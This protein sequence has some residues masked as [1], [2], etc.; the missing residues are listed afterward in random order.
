MRRFV[1][2]ALALVVSAL[3]SPSGAMAQ[4]TITL[5]GVVKSQDGQPVSGAQVIVVNTGTMERRTAGTRPT[6]EFRVLGLYSGKYSVEVRALGYKPVQDSVQLIIGQRARLTIT[7]ERGAAEIAGVAVTAERVRQVEVQRVSIS[8]PVLKEE[9]ENLPMNSRGVM[10]LAAIAPGVK[11]YAPQSG[12]ALPSAGGAPDLRF[13]NLYMDGVEMKSL[14]N[15]NLVGIPQTGSPLPQ[16]ALEEFRVYLNPYDAEYSRAASYVISAVSRRGTD[17]WEGSAFGFFQGKDYIARTFIQERNNAQ[18]P[19]YGRQQYGLNLRG[20]IARG[21]LFFAGSYEGTLTDNYIDVVPATNFANW[22]QYRGAFLAPQKNHT[23]FGRLTAT[24]NETSTYDFMWSTRKLE[25]EGNFGGRSS[26]LAG[27]SQEYL[28]HTAQLRHRWLPTTNLVNELS[29][30]YVQWDHTE[31]PLFPGPTKTYPG[32]ITGTAGFPL[33][34]NEKHYRIVNRSTY[35]LDDVRGSHLIK[36][37]GELSRISASQFLPNNRDGAFTFTTDTSTNPNNAS[38]A[39]GF[40][41]PTGTDDARASA[42]GHTIGFYVNDEWR[43]IPNLA[44]NLGLRYDAE[45]NTLNNDYTVPWAS[46]PVLS[47]IAALQPYLNRGDRK[48]DMNNVS[49]RVSFLL[50][51]FKT[52]RTFLRGGFAIMF[53]R[54]TSFIGFQERLNSEW[55]TYNFVNP[56]TTDPAVLRARV[57]QGGVNAAAQPIL[58]KN[59]LKTPENRQVSIGIGHQFNESFG[60]NVDYVRQDIKNLYVRLNPNWFS[61]SLNRRVLTPAYGDIILWD[62]FGTAKFNGMVT[63]GT[64]NRSGQR[65]N[66]AYTLGFYESDFDGNLAPVFPNRS[67]YDMQPTTGDERHRFV[68]S[69]INRLPLG[70]QFSSV[71]SFASP[72]PYGVFDGRQVNDNNVTFDDFPN[73][74]RTLR[75]SNDWENWYKTVDIR[76]QRALIT[77][78]T[79]KLTLMAEVFNLFNSENISAFGGQQYQANGA[80][81]TTFG[82]STGAFAARQAQLGFRV[83][84]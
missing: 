71:S 27:I 10:N 83:D 53:D 63:Q 22:Q 14:F 13:I 18:L 29:L 55:R 21:K 25:G 54:V 3:A 43:P 8:A 19:K 28:I 52:N 41:N 2:W 59:L 69:T 81:V 1:G 4:N 35:N 36:F 68:M 39:I 30:Q 24:P 23:L 31:A 6:G 74:Q 45:L 56:G 40:S 20:P 73:N 38:V 77:R 66:L 62:D 48:N 72:R 46:D 11:A 26:Q 50:D 9:I 78:G 34:L 67:S 15:G 82:Q 61:R 16:E 32:I 12:R 33:E 58:A 76:L 60:L 84:F 44:I 7:M 42:T 17:K 70:I 51:P 80:A 37:G 49:P 64:W 57:A 75:P 5:E 47:N 65:F 79:Q